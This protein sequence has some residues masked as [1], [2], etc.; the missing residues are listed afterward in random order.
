MAPK[1]ERA[2]EEGLLVRLTHSM[3]RQ[4]E[5]QKGKMTKSK[6]VAKQGHIVWTAVWESNF[7]KSPPGDFH[8]EEDL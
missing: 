2:L 8:A 7:L 5:S 1:M 6:S 4:S 3:V